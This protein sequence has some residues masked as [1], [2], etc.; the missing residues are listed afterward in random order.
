[1]NMV[2][3][4]WIVAIL[5]ASAV[6]A[7]AQDARIQL[8]RVSFEIG[9]NGTV[10]GDIFFERLIAAA[11]APTGGY[12][13]LDRGR[14][15]LIRISSEGDV[16]FVVGGEG[17]GPGEFRDPTS[18]V[19]VDEDSVV[20]F[21]RGLQRVSVFDDDGEFASSV[22][23]SAGAR[24]ARELVAV[25]GG[26]LAV[27]DDQAR[28]VG[29][30]GLARDSVALALVQEGTWRNRLMRL[31]GTLTSAMTVQ[32]RTAV[33]VAPFSPSVLVAAQGGCAVVS[34]TDESRLLILGPE[35][36]VR[37]LELADGAREATSRDW[38]LTRDHLLGTVPEEARDQVKAVLEELP[39]PDRV[40]ILGGLHVD[41]SG[42]IWF[43]PWAPPMGRGRHWRVIDG[44]GAK[45]AELDLPSPTRL[46]TATDSTVLGVS[47]DAFDAEVLTAWQIERGEMSEG[48]TCGG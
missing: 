44:N 10:D 12:W 26:W 27:E 40:P 2:D 17:D 43:Q 21:D 31:P 47:T 30:S 6:P 25:S 1:M 18:V 28:S 8:Q 32:G 42:M 41:V 34:V 33:R 7:G 4:M 46:L 39:R 15:Q 24:P 13:L 45:I 38:E 11:P 29:G 19:S 37:S 3:F 36:L 48:V 35:G 14:K 5:V 16:M 22:Q 20:V 9:G 23:L